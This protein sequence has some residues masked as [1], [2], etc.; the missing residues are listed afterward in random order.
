MP[1]GTEIVIDAQGLRKEF[2]SLTAV[3]GLD[4]TIRR[5]EVFGFLGPNGAGKSTAIRMLVGLLEPTAGSVQVLGYELPQDAERLRPHIGYMT[6]RFSLY[7][8]LSI[9][10]N[11]EFAAEIFGIDGKVR[12]TRVEE[13]LVEFGLD[14]RRR[15]RP[16]TLSGG[17]RQ[18]LALAVATIHEP[19]VLLLDE[20]TAGVDPE[21]RRAFWSK[22]FDLAGLGTTILVSTHYMDEAIRC[23]RLCLIR[24]GRRAAL[25]TPEALTAHLEGRIVELI[26]RPTDGAVDMLEARPEVASVAQLGHHIHVLLGPGG[27]QA[28]EAAAI[29]SRVLREAGFDGV[30]A[31]AAEPDLEDVFVALHRGEIMVGGMLDSRP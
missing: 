8:D 25:G 1:A 7:R 29:F 15:Q 2:G 13:V 5:G 11:L 21:S 16:A 30:A 27:P 23:H 9:E 14:A 31:G 10:E 17:W 20:P 4:L 22:L 28:D 12:R 26:A 18:R 6:Q 3:D 24:D 19:R